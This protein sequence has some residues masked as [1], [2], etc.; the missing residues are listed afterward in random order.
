MLQSLRNSAKSWVMGILFVLLILSFAIWGIGD[1]FRGGGRDT[2]I[3]EVS[4]QEIGA[5][6]F[7]REFQREQQRI[8]ARFGGQLEPDR[9]A[10]GVHVAN[11]MA[12]RIL[13]DLAARD[14]DLG[15][16]DG[17]V[18]SAVRNDAGFQQA[19]Q[20]SKELYERSLN[21]AG[22][23]AQGY[24][25]SL[26]RDLM[27]S[28]LVGA[29]TAVETPPKSLADL[30]FKFRSERRVAEIL[31][32]GDDTMTVG[33]PD[34]AALEAYYQAHTGDFMAP[35]FRALTAIILRPEDLMAEIDV[36]EG[37]L[38]EEYESRRNE[39][40]TPE[41]RTIQQMLFSD[42][43]GAKAAHELLNGGKSFAE[44]AK[45]TKNQQGDLALGTLSREQLLP[46]LVEP[47]F[48]LPK[49]GYTAPLKSPFG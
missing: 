14:L 7:I 46:Q 8:Q 47:V 39:F 38:R 28:Q 22:M 20:F 16:P 18:A 36:D 24:E 44:V 21:A 3:A 13:L 42:E 5:R 19:G 49:D 40:E 12:E 1:I 4:G 6:P 32:V 41:T 48:A 17:V 11:Q 25:A 45:E 31:V 34:Q 29:V 9:M 35:E 30:L 37:T 10:L 15:L 23:T 2:V 33:E 43:A 26:K 27:H